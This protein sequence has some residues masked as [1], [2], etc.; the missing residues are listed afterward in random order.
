MV[1][2]LFGPIDETYTGWMVQKAV[3]VGPGET[4]RKW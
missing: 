2:V 4:R 1:V 3:H